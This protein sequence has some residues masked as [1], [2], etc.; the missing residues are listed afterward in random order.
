MVWWTL[1][2]FSRIPN[3]FVN[4]IITMRTSNLYQVS[5]KFL[6]SH[7]FKKP[8]AFVI[9]FFS[10]IKKSRLNPKK[11]PGY[12][13]FKTLFLYY[14]DLLLPFWTFLISFSPYFIQKVLP[15]ISVIFIEAKLL[16]SSSSSLIGCFIVNLFFM[17]PF[18]V[19]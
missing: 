9:I 3:N 5:K 4:Y 19:P 18:H 12:S 1:C 14:Q 17:Q 2:K 13:Y 6:P 11:W 15:L 10:S 16:C 8:A 7:F